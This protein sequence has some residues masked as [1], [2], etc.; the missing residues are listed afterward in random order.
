MKDLIRCAARHFGVSLDKAVGIA[1]RESRFHP[2]AY[3]SWSCAKGIYQHLCRYWPTRAR[4]YGFNQ[5]VRL[6]RPSQHLRDDA[7]G[8]ALRVAALGRLSPIPHRTARAG[9]SRS[10]ARASDISVDDRTHPASRRSATIRVPGNRSA[11]IATSS[12]NGP[13]TT[14]ACGRSASS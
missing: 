7:D 5:L 3:N 13:T 4:E 6:Q 14:M 11:T 10:A 12:S 1:F 8:E 9:C 2:R